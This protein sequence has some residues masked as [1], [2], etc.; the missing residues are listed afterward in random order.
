MKLE[1]L[2]LA[3]FRS[4]TNL[5]LTF[6]ETT[7]IVGN[8]GAGKTNILE[9]IALLATGTSPR[10]RVTEEMI[11]VGGDL[12]TVG[13]I[14]NSNKQTVTSNQG[15]DTE[16]YTSLTVVLTPGVYL[17]KRTTKRRYL[18]DGVARIRVRFVGY[19]VAVLF[20]PEDLRL[21]EGSPARRRQ[22]L[23]EVLVQ[24]SSEYGRALTAYEGA[25][26][27]RNRLLDEIREGR[28]VRAQLTFWDATLV[29][30]GNILTE[31]RRTFCEYLATCKMPFGEMEVVYQPS[32]VSPERLYKY[33]DEEVAAGYTL[34]G[35]HKDD[36][37]IMV[38]G[39][40]SMD[41]GAYKDLMKY[42]SRGEQRLGVL[43]LKIGSM[44]YLEQE[45]GVKPLLLLDDILS[46][47]DEVHRKQVVE[48]MEGRQT[49]LTT[50]EQESVAL[51]GGAKVISLPINQ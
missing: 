17:G 6:A 49:V 14:V 31:A 45:L 37:K 1:R 42:G 50:A 12:A 20:R 32:T 7:V 3:N 11:R 39:Q 38:N 24:A 28:A 51:V 36:F 9:A 25:L 43:F 22:Y 16:E 23:D 21:V 5:T 47:L 4:Y 18:V 10:T 46:E 2:E 48:L 8:N 26:R 13:G 27:R 19:L 15:G 33:K 41:N 29:K 40:W 34:V 44:Y 35:P 30:N